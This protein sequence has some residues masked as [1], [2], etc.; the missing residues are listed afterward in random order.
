MISFP[1]DASSRTIV[2]P[3]TIPGILVLPAVL[4]FLSACL[5]QLQHT[6]YIRLILL[7]FTLV[8]FYHAA[9][10]YALG[11]PWLNTYN[12]ALVVRVFSFLP[13]WFSK[14]A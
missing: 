6:Y 4:Y 11:D 10:G 13:V 8:S 2:T 1:P 5:V 14:K 3:S 7:P 9:T 12:Q